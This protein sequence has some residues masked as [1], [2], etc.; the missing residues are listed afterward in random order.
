MRRR[1]EWC[2]C[3]PVRLLLGDLTTQL[4]EARLKLSAV[5]R[6]TTP[7][8][9][10]GKLPITGEVLGA[11]A[12]VDVA[13]VADDLRFGPSRLRFG[14]AHGTVRLGA[15]AHGHGPEGAHW[16]SPA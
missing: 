11:Q 1:E 16:I 14:G 10:H 3:S 6:R 9:A 15:E 8:L 4:V 13:D 5:G 7:H 12:V 2:P